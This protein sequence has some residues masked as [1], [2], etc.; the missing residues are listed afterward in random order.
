MTRTYLAMKH[1]EKERTQSALAAAAPREVAGG[2]EP[3]MVREA[4]ELLDLKEGDLVI[5]G[6]LGGGG[7]ARA[8]ARLIGA[9]GTLIGVDLDHRV[10]ERQKAELADL[11]PRVILIR[12]SFAGLKEELAARGLPRADALLLD[13][14]FSSMQVSEGRGFSF[15][16]DEP[17]RMTYNDEEVPLAE[18]LRDLGES[19]LVELLRLTG[20]R[21][22]LRIARAIRETLRRAPIRTTGELVAV[23]RGAV[24]KN[25]E[26]GRLHP[27]TRTFLALRIYANREIE[28]LEGVLRDLP[29]ILTPGGRAAIITFQSI[30]DGIVKRVLREMERAGLL[31][32]LT[33][34]PIPVSREEARANPRA[35]SAKLRAARLV[36]KVQTEGV[37]KP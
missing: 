36:P 10:I 16:A 31:E 22:A 11:P 2:H 24:P 17:L 4:L 26:R 1:R 6:T 35:R 18:Q 32:V 9:T 33:R 5:D 27:A 25:Y 30:E 19:E 34:K 8:M 7:H 3:I 21:Y 13:L 14:G 20:E 12:G 23:V 15:L 29:E 28:R 37:S